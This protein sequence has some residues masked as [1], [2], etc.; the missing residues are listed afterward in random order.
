MP[1]S[2]KI[3]AIQTSLVWENPSANRELLQEKIQMVENVDLIVLPEMFTSGF[4]MNAETVAEDNDGKTLAWLTQLASEKNMAITGSIAFKENSNFYNRMFFVTPSGEVFK[5]DKRHTFTL[6]GE[7]KVY[8]AGKEK[9]IVKYNGWHLCLQ[10]CYDLRF[11]VFARNV[12]DYD[13]MIYVAN[14]PNKRVN[15]WDVLLQARAIENMCYVVGVNRI[16]LDGNN[17]EYSGHSAVYDPLGESLVYSENE[18]LLY[19]TLEKST[20]E[21]Y[22]SGLKFLDDRDRFR[23]LD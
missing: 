1:D 16:G 20:I 8:T 21:K 19:A 6:A 12:E 4:T 13:A 23:L 10:V 22:R 3:A 9:V 11:P 5:Y 17:F 14:W 2:L 15:A 18:E 7:D